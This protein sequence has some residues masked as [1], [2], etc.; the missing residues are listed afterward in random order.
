MSFKPLSNSEL[1][2]IQVIFSDSS[3]ECELSQLEKFVQGKLFK[4]DPALYETTEKLIE[5]FQKTK[6]EGAHA[7]R[8][9]NIYALFQQCTSRSSTRINTRK[10][11]PQEVPFGKDEL[12]TAKIPNNSASGLQ[13][14]LHIAKK[15]QKCVH[16][17][18]ERAIKE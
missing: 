10:N 8:F 4:K 14:L 7:E 17:R 15:W 12:Y 2:R 11:V 6:L 18:Y 13:K 16:A 5:K 9:Q 1:V 3:L